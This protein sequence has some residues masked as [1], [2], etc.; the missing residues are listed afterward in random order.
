M[1]GH[2]PEQLEHSAPANIAP[3]KSEG[4]ATSTVDNFPLER[5]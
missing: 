3:T 4:G 5:E 1:Q 2:G